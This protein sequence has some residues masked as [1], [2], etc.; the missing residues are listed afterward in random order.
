MG[1]ELSRFLPMRCVPILTIFRRQLCLKHLGSI[2]SGCY[3]AY[4][5][6][7]HIWDLNSRFSSDWSHLN[8]AF[9]QFCIRGSTQRH[10]VCLETVLRTPNTAAGWL[11]FNLCPSQALSCDCQDSLEQTGVLHTT[12]HLM[13]VLQSFIAWYWVFGTVAAEARQCTRSGWEA[14]TG[15]ESCACSGSG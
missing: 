11:N 5:G 15:C 2:H 14:T 7:T 1:S 6:L 3:L 10:L 8:P 9:E 12:V 4:H 13:F